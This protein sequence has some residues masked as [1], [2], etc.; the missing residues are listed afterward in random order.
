MD[1]K[2]TVLII[3]RLFLATAVASFVILKAQSE[4][5]NGGKSDIIIGPAVIEHCRTLCLYSVKPGKQ[6]A[7]NITIS[8]KSFG[9]IANW[10]LKEGLSHP[11]FSKDNSSTSPDYWIQLSTLDHHNLN[12]ILLDLPVTA[13]FFG[14]DYQTKLAKL[15][16][17]ILDAQAQSHKGS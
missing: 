6:E 9:N 7:L 15:R 8:S 3:Q 4:T 1:V 5:E 2:I 17:M 14:P 16:S 11:R 13:E 10:I 12:D